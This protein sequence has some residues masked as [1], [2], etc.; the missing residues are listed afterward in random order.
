[1]IDDDNDE[2]Q[3][4][5]PEPPDDEYREPVISTWQ[6]DDVVV[7]APSR[8]PV[9]SVD[10]AAVHI[11]EAVRLVGMPGL[12]A[13]LL[14][15]L[16][17]DEALADDTVECSACGEQMPAKA[18]RCLTCEGRRNRRRV[19]HVAELIRELKGIALAGDPNPSR[20][21]EIEHQLR[22]Y[23]HPDIDA[24]KRWCMSAR[25]RSESKRTIKW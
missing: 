3:E 24:L 9:K 2:S 8:V 11:D 12:L 16:G 5:T 18:K 14:D 4:W 10:Q 23:D 15:R 1:M 19:D 20:E 22:E 17:R 6:D 13:A 21:R 7:V 25:D